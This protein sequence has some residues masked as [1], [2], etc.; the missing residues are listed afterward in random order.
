L[1]DDKQWD[2]TLE[3]CVLYYS[4]KTVRMTFAYILAYAIPSE[5]HRLWEKHKASMCEDFL[6]EYARASVIPFELQQQAEQEALRHIDELLQTF[7]KSLL[8]F[9]MMPVVETISEEERM[10]KE[11]NLPS[12]DESIMKWIRSLFKCGAEQWLCFWDV[13][14]AFQRQNYKC[15]FVLAGA[16]SGKT[17]TLQTII[18]YHNA[19]EMNAGTAPAVVV[20]RLRLVLSCLRMVIQHIQ[21]FIYQS[22]TVTPNKLSVSLIHNMKKHTKNKSN[23]CKSPSS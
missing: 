9:E 6:R 15:F 16:G 14:S 2:A 21:L 7:G 18:D 11:L 12:T 19:F 23:G 1:D 13:M 20:H 10:Q 22:I 8:S 5:P 17:F 3:E 4:P